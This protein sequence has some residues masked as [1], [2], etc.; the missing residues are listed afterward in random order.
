MSN[1]AYRRFLVDTGHEAPS[2]WPRVGP[3][4]D[5]LPVVNVSWRDAVAYAEW[6]G[7]HLPSFAEWTW[8][9]RGAENR[10]YPWKDGVRGELKG[11]V[12][13]DGDEQISVDRAVR[14]AQYFQEAEAVVS[15]PEA[16]SPEGI[17]NLLGNVSELTETPPVQLRD[18]TPI[19]MPLQRIVAGSQWD[20]S[21]PYTLEH[22]GFQFV[23]RSSAD[24][25]TGFRCIAVP[26]S[27]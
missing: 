24:F 25:R 9:A 6:A 19:P 23:E 14:E 15:H 8:A 11:N 1:A 27:P 13:D 7:K 4:H 20:A 12:K 21:I 5:E 26:A 2:H 16:R 3:E 10:L 18:E 22:F 17:Y